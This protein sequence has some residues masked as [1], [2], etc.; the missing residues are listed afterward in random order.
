M[1]LGEFSHATDAKGRV[2]MPAKFRDELGKEFIVTRGIDK[3]LCVYPLSE[4]EKYTARIEEF[5]QVQARKVRRFIYSAACKAELDSQGRVLLTN[6][7]REYAEIGKTVSVLGVG[8]YIEIWASENWD[9]E[10]QSEDASEIEDIM[11]KL[12]EKL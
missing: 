9:A 5:P 11:L 10:K 2:F 1:F 3:C 4:W 7:Q 12:E 8:K 6:E